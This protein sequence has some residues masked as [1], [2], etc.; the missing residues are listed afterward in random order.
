MHISQVVKAQPLPIRKYKTHLGAS[1]A[2]AGPQPAKLLRLD[3]AGNLARLWR[4]HR[5][6]RIRV[7]VVV[8]IDAGKDARRVE[9]ELSALGFRIGERH[10]ERPKLPQRRTDLPPTAPP[11]DN[12]RWI[13]AH[14]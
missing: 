6:C 12:A 11:I 5:H 10:R 13:L 7:S 4:A 14:Q 2:P 8:N 3:D 9:T 1:L